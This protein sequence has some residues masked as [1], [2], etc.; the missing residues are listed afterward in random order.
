MKKGGIIVAIATAV[1]IALS[2]GMK[3]VSDK[4]EQ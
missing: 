1:V 2:V 4:K 3:A